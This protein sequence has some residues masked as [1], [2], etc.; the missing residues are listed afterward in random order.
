MPSEDGG[1]PG[2]KRATANEVHTEVDLTKDGQKR[3]HQRDQEIKDE[4][5]RAFV[6][7]IRATPYGVLLITVLL[8][9]HY[10]YTNN[11][12]PIENGFTYV[13]SALFGGLIARL[14][15]NTDPKN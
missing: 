6:L 4:A 10:A 12:Q 13:I 5:N 7:V 14:K 1:L 2:R 15:Q 11:W 8:L 3:D 9:G